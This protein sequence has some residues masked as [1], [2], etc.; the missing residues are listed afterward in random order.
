MRVMWHIVKQKGLR[1]LRDTPA[2]ISF[3]ILNVSFHLE[4][5]L[6]KEA[7]IDANFK[8]TRK[9]TKCSIVGDG[10]RRGVLA[11]WRTDDPSFDTDGTEEE[12]KANANTSSDSGS[13]RG[14]R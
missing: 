14:G 5:K 4:I 6:K 10:K 8:F 13:R 9:A 1:L 12:A 7:E 2:T 11:V 3:Y